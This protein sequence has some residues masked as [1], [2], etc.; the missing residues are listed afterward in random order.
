LSQSEIDLIGQIAH[1]PHL[2]NVAGGEQR[3]PFWAAAFCAFLAS[4]PR[5]SRWLFTSTGVDETAC[6]HR[7][8][9]WPL[10]PAQVGDLGGI[11]QGFVK[12]EADSGYHRACLFTH[13]V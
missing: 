6:A 3:P 10:H 5:W 4:L 9:H 7:I 8:N 13:I 11:E 2:E 1:Q 12:V